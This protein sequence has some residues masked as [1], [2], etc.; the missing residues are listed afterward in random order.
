VRAL[1]APILGH[2]ARPVAGKKHLIQDLFSE[3]A[4]AAAVAFAETMYALL[5]PPVLPEPK[6]PALRRATWLIAGLTVIADWVGSNRDWFPYHENGPAPKTY[7]HEIARPRARRA[8]AEAG[9]ASVQPAKVTSFGA[10]TGIEQDPSPVQRWADTVPLPYG[11]LLVL[12]E[13]MTGG[14]KT[15]AAIVLAHPLMATGRTSGIYFALPT[16]ATAN[17]M[18]TRIQTIARRLYEPHARP[19]LALAHGRAYLN[20]PFR[21][22]AMATEAPGERNAL[23]VPDNDEDSAL[24]SPEW[25]YSELRKALL[26]DL[27]VGTLDQALLGALPAKYQA[28]RL[29][30]IAEK[31]LIVDEAHA[32]DAYMGKELER[33]IAFQA[34][35]AACS[36]KCPPHARGMN[37]RQPARRPPEKC[38][39]TRGDEPHG[40]LVHAIQLICMKAPQREVGEWEARY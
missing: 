15:E 30:G 23:A 9:L 25:L 39:R 36:S 28:L 34:A 6:G 19:S 20:P 7:W 24:T 11:P 26:A 13:D 40:Q 16:M 10:L 31:V 4:E 33:L 2:H 3:P 29:A 12:I 27:G 22:L 8:L 17:A 32:Y 1:F 38:P 18:F 35:P 37:V 14:G 21:K 5:R